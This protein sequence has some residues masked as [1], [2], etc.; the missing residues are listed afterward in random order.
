MHLV[1]VWLLRSAWAWSQ[2]IQKK[3]EEVS[4]LMMVDGW[5]CQ[6]DRLIERRYRH[7]WNHRFWWFEGLLCCPAITMLGSRR[8][9]AGKNPWGQKAARRAAVLET[10]ATF[11]S[12]SWKLFRCGSNVAWRVSML[13]GLEDRPS[14][15]GKNFELRKEAQMRRIERE[16][17]QCVFWAA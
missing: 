9:Q 8:L 11:T 2:G 6:W 10:S 14:E 5:F 7:D 12:F 4:C 1:S 15:E 13:W 17:W 16:A 3:K